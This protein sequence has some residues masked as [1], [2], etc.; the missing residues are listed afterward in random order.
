MSEYSS[1]P[2]G[3]LAELIS[4]LIKVEE[5]KLYERKELQADLARVTRERDEARAERDQ[6]Q[7]RSYYFE[8]IVASLIP[9]VS[10]CALPPF[11]RGSSGGSGTIE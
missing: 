11:D 3:A 1:T 8:R 6:W 5:D 2:I 10:L 9:P 4:T 7:A